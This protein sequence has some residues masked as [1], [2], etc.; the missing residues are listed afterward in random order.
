[1]KERA[2]ALFTR[3]TADSIIITEDA[4]LPVS[5]APPAT[6]ISTVVSYWLLLPRNQTPKRCITIY[7]SF[8][9]KCRYR[10]KKRAITPQKRERIL[11]T[12]SQS[13]VLSSRVINTSK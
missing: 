4:T 5:R 8:E 13:L 11:E 12:N 6:I 9:G 2:E 7:Y 3:R 10:R 1:M